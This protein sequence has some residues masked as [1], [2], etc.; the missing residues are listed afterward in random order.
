M[1]VY[2]T[3]VF[4]III[5]HCFSSFSQDYRDCYDF[6]YSHLELEFLL[7]EKKIKGFNELYFNKTCNVDTFTIDLFSNFTVDSVFVCNEKTNFIRK[8]NSIIIPNNFFQ[9]STFVIKI[10]YEGIPY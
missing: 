4:L 6:S 9:L 7:S 10:F 3:L 1:S 8:K 2:K 5:S